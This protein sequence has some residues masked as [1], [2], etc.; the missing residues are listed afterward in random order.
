MIFI[1]KIYQFWD[2]LE[3]RLST[4]WIKTRYA[5]FLECGDRCRFNGGIH[6]KPFWRV[7][8][9]SNSRLKLIFK[10]NNS[11]GRGTLFQGSSTLKMGERTFCGEYCVFGSN[12]LVD[13][14]KDVMIAQAVTIRDTDH[15]YSDTSIPMNEQGVSS[16]PVIIE[17]DVWIAHGVTILKGVH[18]AKGAIIA[19]GAVVNQNVEA[20][21]IVGGVPAKKIG[22]RL[23]TTQRESDSE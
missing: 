14:G 19:A 13:I 3:V 23:K 10:G 9:S 1:E 4:I 8:K 12:Q 17:D 20:Y 16:E 11:I 18:I 21:S 22:S 7:Q 15:I 5:I 6:I 2:L